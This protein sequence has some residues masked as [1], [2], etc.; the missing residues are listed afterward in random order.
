M[1]FLINVVR[2]SRPR[3]GGPRVMGVSRG[4]APPSAPTGPTGEPTP[5]AVQGEALIRGQARTTPTEATTPTVETSAPPADTS[6]PP[7]GTSAPPVETLAPLADTPAPQTPTPGPDTEV[8]AAT[9]RAS[10]VATT[11]EAAPDEGHIEPPDAPGPL[12]ATLRTPVSD[13]QSEPVAQPERTESESPDAS[14]RQVVPAQQARAVERPPTPTT[15]AHDVAPTAAATRPSEREQPDP[16][17]SPPLPPPAA[18]ASG[19]RAGPPKPGAGLLVTERRPMP[20]AP[21]PERLHRP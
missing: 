16:S 14:D 21:A 4:V 13:T 18:P 9:P 3:V 12:Q 20:V 2:D 17:V 1:N 7:A 11:D 8:P 5:P 19:A 6:T 15:T 10:Y